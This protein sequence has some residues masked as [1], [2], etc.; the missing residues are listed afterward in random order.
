M[1]DS[2]VELVIEEPA[3][4]QAIPDLQDLATTAA[5]AGLAAAKLA[6]NDVSIALLACD[7]ARIAELNGEF[8]DKSAATN[9]LSWP[10]FDLAPDAT[11]QAPPA[12]DLAHWPR[13]VPLGDI[14]IALQTCTREATEAGLP[15]KNHCMHLILHGTLHLLGYDHQTVPDAELMEGTERQ[16]LARLGVPDPYA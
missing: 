6:P 10:A 15:L 14:A 5:T 3:W 2:P 13:P 16:A 12:P 11:G 8:R 9:V 1:N 4:L 7:D